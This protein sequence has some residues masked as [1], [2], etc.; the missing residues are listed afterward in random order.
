LR[1]VV[2]LEDDSTGVTV[3]LPDGT[4][5]N[6]LG[7]A[8]TSAVSPLAPMVRW[9]LPGKHRLLHPVGGFQ[10]SRPQSR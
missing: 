10:V 6:S 4:L 1:D 9:L 7:T 5:I 2:A 3:A 8:I